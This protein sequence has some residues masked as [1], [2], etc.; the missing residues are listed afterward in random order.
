MERSLDAVPPLESADLYRG[1]G[2][3]MKKPIGRNSR[4][5][6]TPYSRP[7]PTRPH[8]DSGVE[9][10]REGGGSRW[11]LSRLVDPAVRLISG[12]ATR[13][14][15]SLFACPTG[16]VEDGSDCVPVEI[17][18][19]IEAVGDG[20]VSHIS[21]L[22]DA[23][24]DSSLHKAISPKHK[25]DKTKHEENRMGDEDELHQIEQMIK[26]K[27]FSRDEISRLTEILQSR[28][29]HLPAM[30]EG[31]VKPTIGGGAADH[32]VAQKVSP[33]SSK[34]FQIRSEAP[35]EAATP[36]L[37]SNVQDE[38]C[39]S[40]I[41]IAKAY[42]GSRVS[43]VGSR[44]DVGKSDTT[45]G[46]GDGYSSRTLHHP[47]TLRKPALGWPG[48]T[49]ADQYMTPQNQ[50][51]G[52]GIQSS[53]RSPYARSLRSVPKPRVSSRS[54]L[55]NG[56]ESVG[57]IRRSKHEYGT[58]S[59]RKNF[60]VPA[61]VEPSSWGKFGLGRAS[62]PVFNSMEAGE[63]SGTSK[64]KSSDGKSLASEVGVP[65]VPSHSSQVARKILEHLD[66]TFPT[67]KDKTAELK[68]AFAWRKPESPIS[69]QGTATV[70]ENE[71]LGSSVFE[72]PPQKS[73][74]N[75]IQEQTSVSKEATHNVVPGHGAK[76]NTLAKTD[77]SQTRST[78]GTSIRAPGAVDTLVKDATP[79]QPAASSNKAALQSISV[80]K[81]KFVFSSDNGTGF[82][83]P[84]PASQ[85]AF[86]EPPTPSILPA[87]GNSLPPPL[88]LVASAIPSYTFGT[89]RT[90]PPL[91]FSFP[92]TSSS[93]INVT[94]SDLNFTFGS[95][96]KKRISFSS[97]GKD[98][99]CC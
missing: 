22:P 90:S 57:P 29:A 59:P 98:A 71:N 61:S 86:P 82:T 89:K 70:T 9:E 48:A 94:S 34:K 14:L 55:D 88:G 72:V 66:R 24:D 54:L 76:L 17:A 36:L 73:I 83:F 92:S 65:T 4:A 96:N 18:E 53:S 26:G 77:A 23:E 43:G 35:W 91:V 63:T 97:V 47:S 7:K 64:L 67:P 80:Q 15:P 78:E 99:V 81:S 16:D 38:I 37:E 10:G 46:P 39:A 33:E 58:G 27:M 31:Q 50:R 3:K 84:V 30:E 42:M 45:F 28:T 19:D 11:W 5:A 44:N 79:K 95:P 49:V 75:V 12:G 8:G 74:A 32:L 93:S 20:D 40:P 21:A 87:S 13:I 60:N 68:L 52:F 85:A 1:T 69:T 2:G 62:T 41:D 25:D 6:A 56:Y 51:R